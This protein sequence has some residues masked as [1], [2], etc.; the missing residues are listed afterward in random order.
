MMNNALMIQNNNG[1]YLVNGK[2]LHFKL[3]IQT[4][5]KKWFDRMKEYDFVENKDFFTVGQKSPIA[6]G[7]FQE[8]TNHLLTI[9]MAKELCMIQRS[10]IGK[11]MRQYFIQCEESW[12]SPEMI[13]ARANQIQSRMLEEQ[14]NKISLL[15]NQ[16][17]EQKPKVELAESFLVSKGSILIGELANQLSKLP[18][19]KIGQNRLFEW[20]RKHNFLIN[21]G[22]RKN[23][24][25]QRYIEQEL[26]EVEETV[27]NQRIC[28]TTKVTPKGQMYFLKHFK[29]GKFSA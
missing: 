17:Q 18:N 21:K 9:S 29:Q 22:Q 5:Y 2:E 26:F 12:N 25:Q 8:I 3:E 28:F 10:D 13:L 20:L 14:K 23:Q 19:V 27:S 16:L 15:E 7:G 6:N 11:R 1:A 24:P 4:P